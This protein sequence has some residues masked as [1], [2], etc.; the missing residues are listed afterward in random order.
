MTASVSMPVASGG[1]A[2]E[3]GGGADAGAE[4]GPVG[5]VPRG[6]A[7]GGCACGADFVEGSGDVE[8]GAVAV[9]EGGEGEDACADEVF[10]DAGVESGPARAVPLADAARGDAADGFEESADVEGRSVAVV[11]DF[12]CADACVECFVFDGL[13]ADGGPRRAVPLGEV[14]DGCAEGVFEVAADVEGGAVAVV[15]DFEGS[16]LDVVVGEAVASGLEEPLIEG[17]PG[18][19]VPCGD[20]VDGDAVDGEEVAGDVEL[21][22][23]AVVEDRGGAC[24]GLED[25]L[26]RA[27]LVD[28]C[29]A[30]GF[31]GGAVPLGDA[32]DGLA[33]DGG[34]EGA[35]DVEGWAGAV[36]EDGRVE[37]AAGERLVGELVG[38]S[39]VGEG[40]RGGGP[41]GECEGSDRDAGPVGLVLH[42]VIPSLFRTP[43]VPSGR[44]GS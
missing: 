1:E 40:T 43:A 8:L 5:A 44:P 24:F 20:A 32:A 18:V 31:E 42:G 15:E 19:A 12:E 9:V 13:A 38:E 2:G 34:A 36:V 21:V 25:A 7:F 10:E 4:G 41:D 17:G 16:D 33:V 6:D 27:G 39:G 30:D 37:D 22:A 23:V 29:G 28:A 26:G 11:E 3:A 14:V 35:D